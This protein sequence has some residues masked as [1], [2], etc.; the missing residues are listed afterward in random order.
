MKNNSSKYQSKSGFKVPE[1]YFE[2]LEAN[3]MHILG[4]D[5]RFIEKQERE[6]LFYAS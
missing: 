4:E 5:K 6:R 3:M 2:E 1:N